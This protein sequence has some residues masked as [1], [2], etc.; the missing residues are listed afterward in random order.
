MKWVTLKKAA[1]LT[2]YSVHALRGK[3][4]DGAWPEGVL[5]VKAPDGRIMINIQEY[6]EWVKGS[7]RVA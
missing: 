4:R 5:W 7:L 6:Q 1:E 3:C 2:G